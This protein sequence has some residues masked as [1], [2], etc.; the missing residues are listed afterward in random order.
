MHMSLQII[1]SCKLNLGL[2]LNAKSFETPS[3]LLEGIA[4]LPRNE[5]W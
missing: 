3:R 2:G 5:F 1:K 4:T